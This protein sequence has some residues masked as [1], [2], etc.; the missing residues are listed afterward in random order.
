MTFEPGVDKTASDVQEEV[1]EVIEENDVVLFMKG[2]KHMPQCGY[3]KTALNT[4]QMYVDNVTVVNVMAGPTDAYRDT[5]EEISEW[6]TIPQAF[7]DGEF[8]GG[9]DVIEQLHDEGKLSDE[10]GEEPSNNPF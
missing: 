10:L 8:I 3:S 5:L 7:V 6:N 4:L 9:S 2:T 1:P